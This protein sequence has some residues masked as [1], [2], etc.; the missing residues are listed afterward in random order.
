MEKLVNGKV[1]AQHL[2]VSYRTIMRW[3][4]EGILPY[5][6]LGGEARRRKTI[7]FRL[8]ELDAWV[9]ASG[10]GAAYGANFPARRGRMRHF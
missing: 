8:S 3:A 9:D 6:V 4:E 1:A 2:G 7:R 5:Y 10:S